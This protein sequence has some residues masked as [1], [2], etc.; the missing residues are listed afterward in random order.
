M[1]HAAQTKARA[2]KPHPEIRFPRFAHMLLSDVCHHVPKFAPQLTSHGVT[3][4]FSAAAQKDLKRLSRN[5]D[6]TL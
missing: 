1:M 5:K 6:I 2:I 4:L 3:S